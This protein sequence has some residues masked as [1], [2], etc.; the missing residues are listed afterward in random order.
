[1]KNL[2]AAAAAAF[3]TACQG[4]GQQATT[5]EPLLAT[6]ALQPTTGSKAFG[7][8]TFEQAGNAVHLLINAQGLK[9]DQEHRLH[10]QAGGCG[11]GGGL[12]G[13]LPA[14][15]ADKGGRAR[16]DAEVAGITLAPG[17]RSVIGRGLV[18]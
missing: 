14:L 18:I 13:D 17:P 6:A 12:S 16:L 8:A 15:K 10:L 2:I 3:I 9:P 11:A 4:T 5:S 7:E 1:M